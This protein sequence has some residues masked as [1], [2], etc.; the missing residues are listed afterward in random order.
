MANAKVVLNSKGIR[1]ILN[2]TGVRA[3]LDRVSSQVCSRVNAAK[4]S[5]R[6][7]Y[8]YDVRE[9]SARAHGRIRA[10]NT[11]ANID[12]SRNNTLLK[13]L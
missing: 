11:Q 2:S 7:T 4:A 1:E 9:G 8:T 10:A 6:A 3:E 13:G 5:R 12:N